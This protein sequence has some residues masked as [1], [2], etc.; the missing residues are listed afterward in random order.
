MKYFYFLLFI[1]LFISIS[2]CCEP[3]F[4][5]GDGNT[6]KSLLYSRKIKILDS[7]NRIIRISYKD[8]D[9]IFSP[10]DTITELVI[11]DNKENTLYIETKND[12]DTIVLFVKV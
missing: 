4:S 8:S 2:S 11:S 12:V 5:G 7:T 10:N 1:L 9:K 3:D 6:K